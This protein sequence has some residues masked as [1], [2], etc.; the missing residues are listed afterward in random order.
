[1]MKNF[2]LR[3]LTKL[4]SARNIFGVLLV[5]AIF[6]AGCYEFTY[7]GQ[8]TEAHTN[9]TFDVPLI[10]HEDDGGND[11]TVSDLQDIGLFGVMIPEGWSVK[12]SIFFTI[13]STDAQ[14]NND[15]YLVYDADNSQMLED[16][17]PSMDGY[18]WWGA[19]TSEEA[20]M[21]YFDSLYFTPQ[22]ITDGQ[23]GTFYLRYAIGDK[24]YW[25]RYPADDVTDPQP[26]EITS[27][28]GV[29]EINSGNKMMIFPNPSD[30]NIVVSLKQEPHN[31]NI[32]VYNMLGEL[33][34]QSQNVNNK[35]IFNLSALTKG[36]YFVNLQK[37]N[38]VINTQKL[39][40]K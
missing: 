38:T 18:F 40:L 31:L 15:G 24:D 19:V 27:A 30:G 7:V 26:I 34:F 17:I 20:D 32:N 37:N 39:I 11:W 6:L 29:N 23:V 1:M 9:S 4:L 2:T 33:V 8:P 14:Y 5:L 28:A 21:S 13:I 10:A 36:I 16:S 12:D 25:D 3:K 35:N 22:I